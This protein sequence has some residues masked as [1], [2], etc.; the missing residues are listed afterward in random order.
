MRFL[1]VRES[2]AFLD[3]HGFDSLF[4]GLLGHEAEVFEERADR[5]VF[6]QREVA[7]RPIEPSTRIGRG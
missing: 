3:Q 6:G 7:P 4:G 5:V 1:N 2:H